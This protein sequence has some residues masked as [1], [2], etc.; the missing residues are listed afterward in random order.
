[1]PCSARMRRQF[2][3]VKQQVD[4]LKRIDSNP[5]KE[6]Q[7]RR[8][9]DDLYAR[10]VTKLEEHEK[11]LARLKKRLEDATS[12]LERQQLLKEIDE[13]EKELEEFKDILEKLQ[14]FIV[15]LQRRTLFTP[16]QQDE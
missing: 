11:E 1:M 6:K 5:E 8:D 12:E 7:T 14:E 3:I 16:Q 15:D 2:V 4:E 9:V 10:T 13:L